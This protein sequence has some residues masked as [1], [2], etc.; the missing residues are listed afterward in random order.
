MKPGYNPVR[1]NRNIGTAK[2]GHGT[3]N[4]LVIPRAGSGERDWTEQLKRHR[5][6]SG[7]RFSRGIPFIVEK[8]RGACIHA[9]SVAD[10][11]HVL[12]NIPSDDLAGLAAIVLRQPTRKQMLLNPVWGR[13]VYSADF[14]SPTGRSVATGP[15]IILE[16]V[17]CNA[18]YDW[19]TALDP[20]DMQELERLRDDGH[21]ISRQGHRHTFSMTPDSVRATQLYRTLLH[22]IG[23]WVN[24][25]EAVLRPARAA[26]TDVS[27]F[28]KAY[29]SRPK[30]EREAFAH[31]YADTMRA[32]LTKFGIIPFD[33]IET[34]ADT[35]GLSENPPS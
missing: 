1:R 26:G 14:G 15:A 4:R 11:S 7:T 29:F 17:D 12:A 6:I 22:E 2:Q 34:L 21:A 9:C 5:R 3:N 30:A 24:Y 28:S 8:T 13:L 25:Q 31:R 19:P 33:R 23:H 35:A 10:I 27:P 32:R 16:A 20:Q 18:S